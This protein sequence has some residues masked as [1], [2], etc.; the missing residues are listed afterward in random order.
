[1][2]IWVPGSTAWSWICSVAPA[3]GSAGLVA[4]SAVRFA[5]RS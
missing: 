4:S 5:M 3:E 1:M 2:L